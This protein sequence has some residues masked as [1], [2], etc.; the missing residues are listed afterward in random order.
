MT[1]AQLPICLL[2]MAA[3]VGCARRVRAPEPMKMLDR[4]YAD[5]QP[6]WRIRVVT[7]ILKSGKYKPDFKEN[8]VVG[9]GVELAAGDDFVGYETSFY[10]VTVRTGAGVAITFASSESTIKGKSSPQPQPLVR[11]FDFPASAR[12]VRLL[13]LTRVSRADHNQA[14]LAAATLA[15]LTLLT[16]QVEADPAANCRSEGDNHCEWVPE[17][18]AVRVEH[19]DPAHHSTWLQVN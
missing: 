13:F 1:R 9:G 18:I 7:P 11:L 3:L 8:A 10:S 4:S 12:Y 5:L 15:D 14:I 17:G 2:M 6:G 19:R 16:Q